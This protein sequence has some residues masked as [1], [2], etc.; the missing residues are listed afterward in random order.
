M[1]ITDKVVVVTGGAR[2]IG[3]GLCRAFAQHGAARIVCLD[4]DAESGL[5]VADEC[6]GDFHQV[7]VTASKE[8]E[9]TLHAVEEQHGRVD[10]MCSNAGMYVPDTENGNAGS[11]PD[12]TWQRIWEVNVM[13]HVTAARA[14]LPG[15]TQRGSGYFL[16]TASAAGLLSHIGSAPYAVTKHAAVGFAESLAISHGD[17]GIGVSVL[18][19]QGVDTEMLRTVGGTS[20]STL[21]GVLSVADVAAA[22]IAGLAEESFLILPHPQV[23]DYYARKAANYDRWIGGMRK[24]RRTTM[25]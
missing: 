9:A 1:Q 4:L 22:T 10:L 12:A 7:D 21:D 2:G 18:C 14:L 23:L 13:S 24:L 3:A 5:A 17:Q 8:L 20:A 15:M 6:A 16:I 11:C 19:P 25:R